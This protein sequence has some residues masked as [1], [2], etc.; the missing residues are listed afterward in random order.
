MIVK[1]EILPSRIQLSGTQR[2]LLEERLQRARQSTS[3]ASEPRSSIPRRTRTDEVPLSFAQERLWFLDQL[4]PS[5]A[6]Y[7]VCQA[8]RMK[9]AL[10]L[11]A[12]EKSLNEIIRRHEILR[13]NFV[14]SD[15]RA[16]QV[17][18][19]ER[20]I[21]ITVVDLSAWRDGTAGEEGRRRRHAAGARIPGRSSAFPCTHVTGGR[22]GG[23]A[24]AAIDASAQGAG[25]TGRGDPVHDVAGCVSGFT[26]PLDRPGRHCRRLGRCRPAEGRA[27]ET[28]RILR[29]H[30]RVAGRP[31]R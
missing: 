13:T 6:V 16:V 17:I 5:S 31:E 10:D 7:N 29:E 11:A 21:A 19:L 26:Q 8:V 1:G 22:T 25:P 23:H 20:S 27:R 24:P 18:A 2:A 28:D 12:L 9:G 14:T 30:P 4:E 3:H 15:G